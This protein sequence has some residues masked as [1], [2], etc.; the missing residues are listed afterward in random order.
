[1][2]DQPPGDNEYVALPPPPPHWQAGAAG[3][4]QGGGPNIAQPPY[5][6]FF[7]PPK[8]WQQF[9]LQQP[10][11]QH[12]VP[13]RPRPEKVRLL[14]LHTSRPRTWFMLTESSFNQQ[15]VVASRM[16]FEFIVLALNDEQIRRVGAIT[17]TPERFADP[18]LANQDAPIGDIPAQQM[19]QHLL[20][21]LLQRAGW[22]AAVAAHG[23]APGSPPRRRR[24]W[25]SL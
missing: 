16:K 8:F 20:H 11:Q 12:A 23:R 13:P 9:L 10:N 1:M 24:T 25:L 2:E 5:V 22:H 21:P 15:N 14:P 19:G 7:P 17:E 4:Q 6:P 18:Y 3:E